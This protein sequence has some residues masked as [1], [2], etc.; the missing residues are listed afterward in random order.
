LLEIALPLAVGGFMGGL[1][2][3][4]YGIGATDAFLYEN[5]TY[6]LE[7]PFNWAQRSGLGYL[8]EPRYL[9]KFILHGL[10]K[11]STLAILMLMAVTT[12]A[13]STAKFKLSI[14]RQLM[15]TDAPLVFSL[16]ALAFV[17][18]FLPWQPYLHFFQPFALFLAL[19][20]PFLFVA[21]APLGQLRSVLFGGAILIGCLPGSWL[22]V[23]SGLRAFDPRAWTVTE[24]QVASQDIRRQI[25][26][27]GVSGPVLTLSPIFALD[28][29][30]PIYRELSVGPFFFR[31]ADSLSMSFVKS[32]NGVSPASLE[33]LLQ[34][35]P[36]AAVL[37]GKEP[38]IIEQPLIDYAESHGFEESTVTGFPEL[39]LFVRPAAFR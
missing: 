37:V 35:Q 21:L 2:L 17:F 29:G 4:S 18:G 15:Y 27:S 19:S 36:P 5:Y 22:L 20:V 12:V 31:I 9:I 24:V 38:A 28:A 32:L 3:L 23:Q 10:L 33:G 13:M 26:A 7:M 34:R 14:R 39:R 11:D 16:A 6:Y 25:E 30:L 1:L 8:F